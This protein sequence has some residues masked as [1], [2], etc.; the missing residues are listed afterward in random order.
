[1]NIDAPLLE[2]SSSEIRSA[3][4]AGRPFRHYLP[5]GVY[6]LIRERQLY[7]YQRRIETGFAEDSHEHASVK[8]VIYGTSSAS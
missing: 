3:S 5:V 6:F 1:M 2:I 4:H 7:G 8:F